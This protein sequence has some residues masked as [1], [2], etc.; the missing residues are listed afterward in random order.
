MRPSLF[1]LCA[2]VLAPEAD[3]RETWVDP[4]LRVEFPRQLGGLQLSC[5]RTYTSGD[6]DYSLRYDSAESQVRKTGGQHLDL[7]VYT[8]GETLPDG[9][10]DQVVEEI[11]TTSSEIEQTYHEVQ[12]SEMT[13]EGTF[14]KSKLKFL[15]TSYTLALEEHS[16]PHLSIT[17]VTA[18][19]NRF[20]K[21]RY[22]EDAPLGRLD[23]CEELPKSIQPILEA[24]DA[25]YDRVFPDYDSIIFALVMDIACTKGFTTFIFE[26]LGISSHKLRKL[27]YDE[28]QIV[29]LINAEKILIDEAKDEYEINDERNYG[30]SSDE[31]RAIIDKLV[32]DDVVIRKG[33][34]LR[35]AY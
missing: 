2:L 14:R 16:P 26:T 28:R 21:L 31:I 10:G 29:L 18:W 4:V 7:Y 1:L 27:N 11:R 24:I 3:G 35:I 9:V 33:R 22:S 32:E 6:D 30:Y 25:L 20:V 19:R 13:S 23:P 34:S 8:R 15:W 12:A 5:R 17:L